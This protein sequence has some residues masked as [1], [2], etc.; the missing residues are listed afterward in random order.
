MRDLLIQDLLGSLEACM[1][2][3]KLMKESD[4]D[5]L[6]I[7]LVLSYPLSQLT[8]IKQEEQ[9]LNSRSKMGQAVLLWVALEE[10]FP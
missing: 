8:G 5:R 2:W 1:L 3:L 4:L 6:S 7:F 9:L 10:L